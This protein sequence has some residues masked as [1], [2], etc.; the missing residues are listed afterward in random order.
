M[1]PFQCPPIPG[2]K[3]SFKEHIKL[4]R[5]PPSIQKGLQGAFRAELRIPPHT[6]LHKF[7]FCHESGRMEALAHGVAVASHSA[8][9]LSPMWQSIL[10]QL[11]RPSA[12]TGTV[13]CLCEE[14][15]GSL[16]HHHCS[17]MRVSSA[18]LPTSRV[19]WASQRVPNITT[20][21]SSS[22]RSAAAARVIAQRMLYTGQASPEIIDVASPARDVA[23][24]CP[25]IPTCYLPSPP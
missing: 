13:A 4:Q 23:H 16:H 20:G 17:Q 18:C 5:P 10:T 19:V 7:P 3:G 24:P 15:C 6:T 9:P 11:S 22:S 25:S 21:P 2:S 14:C 1:E 8:P 12:A